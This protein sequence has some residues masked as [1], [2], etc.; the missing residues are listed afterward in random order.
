MLTAH[1]ARDLPN[2][3]DVRDW[4]SRA[5]YDR[6]EA[7]ELAVSAAEGVE[8]PASGESPV[9]KAVSAV[10]GM[11]G[12]DDAEAADRGRRGRGAPG[13]HGAGEGPGAAPKAVGA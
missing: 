8:L 9:T 4:E 12:R 6:I 10:K 2:P 1:G 13:G 5:W 7:E 11:L 3:S